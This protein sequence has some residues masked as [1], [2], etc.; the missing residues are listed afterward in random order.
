MH[1]LPSVSERLEALEDDVDVL[2]GGR[3]IED[4]FERGRVKT[5][6]DLRIGEDEGAEVAFLVP[7]LHRV[8]LHDSIRVASVEAG[9]NE[10]EQQPVRE[11]ETVRGLDVAAHPLWVDDESVD[12]PREA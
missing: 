11:H 8:A 6:R 12:D 1:G 2:H 10:S 3:Q 5:G 4:G 7:G 9:C